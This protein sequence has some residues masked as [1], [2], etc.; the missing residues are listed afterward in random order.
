MSIAVLK[1]VIHGKTIELAEKPELADGQ[2]VAVRVEPEELPP[3]WLERF[4]VDPSI[5]LGKLLVKRTR[6]LVEDL[7]ARIEEGRSNE[8]L[9]QLHPEL[10]A[11]DVD[12]VRHY[13]KV[14]SGL[15]LS[16]GGWAE[17]AEELDEYIEWTRQHRK[18]GRREIEA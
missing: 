6:L 1:G 15:R 16:F 2:A 10:T 5:A 17:D 9:R 14:P 8:D 4:T 7:V 12:A 3:A 11:E 18:V 13:A